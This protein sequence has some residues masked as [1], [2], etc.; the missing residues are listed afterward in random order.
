MC[1]VVAKTECVLILGIQEYNCFDFGV[2]M[3]R[4]LTIKNQIPTENY[5]V[6]VIYGIVMNFQSRCACNKVAFKNS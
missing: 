3:P 6:A 4:C 1:H 5:N 2:L